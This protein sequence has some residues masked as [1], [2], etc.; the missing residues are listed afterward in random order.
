[1]NL[2]YKIYNIG[3]GNY[4]TYSSNFTMENNIIQFRNYPTTNV[5]NQSF[6]NNRLRINY[7]KN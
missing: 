2:K 6:F 7:F 4:K 1:M 3:E 5:I